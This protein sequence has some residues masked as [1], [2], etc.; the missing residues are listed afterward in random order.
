MIN[1]SFRDTLNQVESKILPVN[2]VEHRFRLEHLTFTMD[3]ISLHASLLTSNGEDYSIQ[4]LY[5]YSQK[6]FTDWVMIDH[7]GS[8]YQVVGIVSKTL[9]YFA[10]RSTVVVLEALGYEVIE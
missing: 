3:G 8:E 1:K 6:K 5:S 9:Y 2:H 4:G 10:R 7:L